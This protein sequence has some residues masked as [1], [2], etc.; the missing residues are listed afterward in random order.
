MRYETDDKTVQYDYN[1]KW[2]EGSLEAFQKEIGR[3]KKQ[4][5]IVSETK[6]RKVVRLRKLIGVKP[7]KYSVVLYYI[8]DIEGGENTHYPSD[9]FKIFKG[10]NLCIVLV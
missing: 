8:P 10:I 1:L 9:F 5:R 7:V 4:I 6:F 3:I 2:L